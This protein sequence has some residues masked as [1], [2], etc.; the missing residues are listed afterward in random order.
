[1]ADLMQLQGMATAAGIIA[2]QIE[3]LNLTLCDT[4]KVLRSIE[5]LQD[6]RNGGIMQIVD[7]IKGID[8]TNALVES[9]DGLSRAIKEI[10]LT[11]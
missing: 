5:K 2:K 11:T 3:A 9:L 10:D 4:N 1:M 6:E 7:A 8:D